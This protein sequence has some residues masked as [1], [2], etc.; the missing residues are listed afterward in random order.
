MAQSAQETL[1]FS[2]S[3]KGSTTY[4]TQCGG[5]LRCESGTDPDKTDELGGFKEVYKCESCDREGTF[6]YQYDPVKRSY[7]GICAG[8]HMWE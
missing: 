6:E 7:T 8:Q 2:G 1:Q 3:S 5:H 4:C